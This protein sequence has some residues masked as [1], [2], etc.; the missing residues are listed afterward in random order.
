MFF[1]RND[2]FLVF[3]DSFSAR[4]APV[5]C[6]FFTMTQ[7]TIQRLSIALFV[8]LILWGAYTLFVYLGVPV[9][10][11]VLLHGVAQERLTQFCAT[12]E[13]ACRGLFAFFPFI[14]RTFERMQPLM[15]YG[16]FS[17]IAYIALLFWMGVRTGRFALQMRL[18]SWHM[19]AFFL[20]ALTGIFTTISFGT[21]EAPTTSGVKT[22]PLRRIIEPSP[23]VYRNVGQESLALLQN[24]FTRLNDANCLTPNGRFS[25]AALQFLISPRCIYGSFV[26]R[27]LAQVL[28]I[29]LILF[30]ILVLG[31]FF[32]TLLRLRYEHLL[33]EAVFSMAIGACAWVA[34]LWTLAVIGILTATAGW[35][36]I[37]AIP[38]L[39][40]RQVLFWTRTFFRASIPVN[41]PWYSA[42][43]FLVWLLVSY[44]AL[45]FLNVVRPFPIGWDDLGS[46]INR[47]R[48]MVSYGKFIFSMAPFMWEY[49]SSLGFLLFGYSSIF[50]ATGSMLINWMAGLLA[51]LSVLAFGTVFLGRG[52][53]I[54][55]AVLYYT[56]PLVGHFS[57][58]DMKIDNSVF[59]WGTLGLLALF[60]FLFPQGDSAEG[61]APPRS[62]MWLILS[63][64]FFGFGFA[65]KAT[66]IMVILASGAV[67]LGALFHWYAFIGAVFLAIAV[68]GKRGVLGIQE[69]LERVT[70]NPDLISQNAFVLCA[71]ILGLGIV[72]FGIAKKRENLRMGLRSVGVLIGV[73]ALS[74]APWIMHNNILSGNIIPKFE[75]GAPNL[76]TPQMDI[77][78]NQKQEANR[79]VRSLPEDL[80]VNIEDPACS[81][82]GHKE[83]LGR[84]W[85]Y[86]QGWA[87]YLKLPWRSV[88]NLDSAGY[89]VTTMPALLLFPLLLLLP[90]FWRKEGRWLRWLFA[91]TLFM[92]MQWVFMA[93]GIPWYGIGT[94][95]GLV[96]GLEALVVKAPDVPSRSVLSLLI[97]LSLLI[98]LNNRFWQYEMQ[99]NLFEYPMGKVSYETLR[100]RTI[101]YYDDIADIVLERNES[102]PDRPYLYRVGTFIPYFIP[103]NLEMIGAADHQLD[104][105]NC[106]YQEQDPKLTTRRLKALGFN[107]IVFDTNTATIERNPQGTLHKKVNAFVGY[108]N[109]PESGL[110]AVINQ[111]QAG[112]AF[113]L[114]P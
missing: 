29:A 15:W 101:P 112:V 20:L 72:G 52:R 35:V 103:R 73:F 53:G 92:L 75:T 37:V 54:L 67:I 79:N 39:C 62:Y 8:S 58:A 88:M 16:I 44:L 104:L 84:Y 14:S 99:K 26:S 60:L 80:R 113:I 13:L 82:T 110:Q 111:A 51:V 47:P 21:T 68:L 18:K 66:T 22:V 87:H 76:L 77:S 95:L 1:A 9:H 5:Y 32:F 78:G 55:A 12:E 45:N 90:Y 105:F 83:E 30:E 59:M 48:L 33:V 4:L 61:E 64:I 102:V 69:I 91:G 57:F 63:G 38:V 65:T 41:L 19:V 25:D 7:K 40:Y 34:L 89:Y 10:G 97:C 31:H 11:S 2:L 23:Q 94:F 46:Y 17:I 27:V 42:S 114:I 107:S 93:R 24:N 3:C 43:T 6:V 36:F 100:E 96:I 28:F 49:L 85:G 109:N 50:G 74:I 86:R 106:L 108:L 56:L 70:G 81:P 71:L 98:V